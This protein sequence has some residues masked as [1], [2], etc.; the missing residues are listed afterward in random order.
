MDNTV[1]RLAKVIDININTWAVKVEVNSINDINGFENSKQKE[2]DNPDWALPLLP[3]TLFTPPKIG[4]LVII[5]TP[6][7]GD[8]NIQG[9][10]YYIGP[11]ISQD[12]HMYHEPADIGAAIDSTAKVAPD[13]ELSRLQDTYGCFAGQNDVAVYGRKNCELILS[14]GRVELRADVRHYATGA[15]ENGNHILE[16]TNDPSYIIL[17]SSEDTSKGVGSTA[18]IVADNI[19]FIG[20]IGDGVAEPT[21]DTTSPYDTDI[22]PTKKLEEIIASAH[23]LPFGDV[24]VD[25]LT[26]FV[27]VFV[28][29]KHNYFL[30]EPIK[31]DVN[32]ETVKHLVDRTNNL[33]EELLSKN[34]RIN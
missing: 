21:T 23:T 4:E 31:E 13:V 29:H 27:N 2:I 18:T 25:F 30:R 24:L 28:H 10:K 12:N 33:K 17:R 15:D 22:L 5:F 9:R 8:N 20:N 34:V 7:V 6:S 19:N 32:C 3:K 26:E 14:D 1:T 11:V 16:N